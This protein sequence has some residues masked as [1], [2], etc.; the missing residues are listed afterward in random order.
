MNSTLE[1]E[2]VIE[3]LTDASMSIGALRVI[4]DAEHL[5]ALSGLKKKSAVARWCRRSGI[6]FFLNAGGW[7]V[8]IPAALDRALAPDVKCVRN[9]N[10]MPRK[11]LPPKVHEKCG[12]YYYV[13]QNKWTAL[14]RVEEGVRELHRR[15]AILDDEPPKTLAYIFAK[16]AD[17]GMLELKPPTQKQ[18]LYYLFGILDQIF[19]HMAPGDLEPTHVA[20][21]LERRKLKGAAVSGNR[22]RACLSSVFEFAMRRGWVN[23]NPCRGVRR[24]RE[25]PRKTLIES[26]DLRATLDRAPPHFARVMAFAYLTGVRMTD[27]IEMSLSAVT[28]AGLKFTE[29]KTGKS[30]VIG[31]TPTLRSLVR[32]ITKA[33][34]ALDPQPEHD[35]LLTNRFGQPLTQWGIISNIRRLGVHWSFRDIRPKAQTDGGDRNVLG[36]IGQMR[37]RYTR[38]NKRLPVW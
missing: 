17:E 26:Q 36:H 23:S 2:T 25:A 14:S 10:A 22:E 35:R 8:T 16:Y 21:Y 11:R 3:T 4:V 19:G 38:A 27:A 18:Y 28:E 33:R 6:Q 34:E 29:S 31:W 37:G 9:L 20:Q 12:R 5:K 13:H 30:A 32:E 24:N 7:P 1:C 15:L